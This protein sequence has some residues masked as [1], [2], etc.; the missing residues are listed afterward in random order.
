[1]KDLQTRIDKLA[2][3]M[4]EFGLD[5]ASWSNESG[6]VTFERPTKPQRKSSNSA[7]D[8]SDAYPDLPLPLSPVVPVAPAGVPISSPMPG[9]YYG[10]SSPSTPPFV[11]VGEVVSMGQVIGLIEAMKVFNEIPSP[12]SGTVLSIEVQGG[13]LV[14]IGEVLMR[15]G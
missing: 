12:V 2:A 6:Q 10:A 15:I 8:H 9:I 4:D 1:M 13:D 5:R 7:E 3:L 11:R 14:Q